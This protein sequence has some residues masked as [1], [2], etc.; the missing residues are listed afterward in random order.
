GRADRRLRHGQLP[1]GPAGGQVGRGGD[2]PMSLGTPPRLARLREEMAKREIAALMLTAPINVGWATGFTGSTAAALITAADAIFVTDSRY[3][4]QA[5]RECPGFAVRRCGPVLMETVA[6]AART[7]GITTLHF[8]ANSVTVAQFEKW[9]ETLQ[10]IQ[11][12]PA[13]EV[14]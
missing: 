4:L 11:L 7:A 9:K 12:A 14:V 5:E 1:A 3:A 8:E 6:E 13:S 10:P 2:A